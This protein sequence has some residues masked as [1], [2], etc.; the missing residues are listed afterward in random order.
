MSKKR[1]S[2]SKY[3]ILG[4]LASKPRSGYDIKKAIEKSIGFFWSE[5]YGQIYP[6]LKQLAAAGLAEKLPQDKNAARQTQIYAITDL[7]REH[8]QSWIRESPDY[9][10]VRNEVLLKLFFGDQCDVETSVNHLKNY[11][12]HQKILH[13]TFKGFKST[14]PQKAITDIG[15]LT[16]M[17]ATLHHGIMITKL[18]MDWAK[19]TIL[20]L[21]GKN[22]KMLK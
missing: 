17:F 9:G 20:L 2:R 13:E 18:N 21:Q 1:T 11:I 14:I 10:G 22:S 15:P 4:F 7:G 12:S 8:L 19:D 6:I 3:A 5:S 16:Y